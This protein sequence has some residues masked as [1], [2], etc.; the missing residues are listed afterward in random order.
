MTDGCA[1]TQAIYERVVFEI[2]KWY[3][4]YLLAPVLVITSRSVADGQNEHLWLKID[5]ERT[6]RRRQLLRRENGRRLRNSVI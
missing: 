2:R 6:S 4:T 1:E 3:F 5:P